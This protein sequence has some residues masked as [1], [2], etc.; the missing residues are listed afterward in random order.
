MVAVKFN[1]CILGNNITNCSKI[2][3]LRNASSLV[4]VLFDKS[5]AIDCL[6]LQKGRDLATSM[7]LFQS[8]ESVLR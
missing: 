4:S 8:L 5:K 1:L 3:D 7:V 2:R 6:L